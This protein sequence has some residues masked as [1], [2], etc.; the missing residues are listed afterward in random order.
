MCNTATG[1]QYGVMKR[2]CR[3]Q[4]LRV[5]EVVHPAQADDFAASA[6]G[7]II[8]GV[9]DVLFAVK[10]L[11]RS[12]RII[13]HM[14]LIWSN[15][16]LFGLIVLLNAYTLLL[17]LIPQ[18]TYRLSPLQLSAGSLG[19]RLSTV[20]HDSSVYR[21]VVPRMQLDVPVYDNDPRGLQK[22]VAHRPDTSTPQVGG[23]TVLAAHRFTY[24]NPQGT[25][26]H[27]DKLVP[28][29]LVGLVWQGRSYIYAVEASRITGPTDATVEATTSDDRLT[30]YTCTPLWNPTQRLVV[31]ARKVTL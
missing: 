5:D 1:M 26:Y 14:K 12:E 30:L 6:T 18:L 9:D 17:P 21:L 4:P 31:T 22:G 10:L 7:G 24:T 27:L 23:N 13:K 2:G 16:I 20:D 28:G 19:S 3:L 25:F 11:K 8:A 15:R 29:D